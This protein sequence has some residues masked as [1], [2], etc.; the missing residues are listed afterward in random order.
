MKAIIISDVDVAGT[1]S[2]GQK[3]VL[4]QKQIWY[5]YNLKV[6]I[7]DKWQIRQEFDDRNFVDP[8]RQSQFLS[9]H[10]PPTKDRQRL[11]R[12]GWICLLH[13]FLSSG[14]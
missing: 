14:A 3:E 1:V 11:E 13:S 9:P 7:G 8:A 4:H 2:L 10:A 12:G 5:K 6:P